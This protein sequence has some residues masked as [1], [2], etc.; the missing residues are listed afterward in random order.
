MENLQ[1][2]TENPSLRSGMLRV[3]H[4]SLYNQFGSIAYGI[5]LKIIPHERVAQD[6]LIDVF[7]SSQLPQLPAATNPLVGIVRVARIKALEAK[8]RLSNQPVLS[9]LKY[10]PNDITPELIFN[11]SFHQGYSVE[12][13][14][15]QFAMDKSEV[16]KAI[17]EYIKSFRQ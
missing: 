1:R 9:E 14:A 3:D 4:L 16:L 17:R 7:T 15:L 13:I 12:A 11:L 10:H 8:E 2:S 6:V 5:I